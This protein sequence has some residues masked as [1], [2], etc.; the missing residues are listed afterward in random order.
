MAAPDP[1]A[2]TD[3]VVEA[4]GTV[5]VAGSSVPVHLVEV[6]GSTAV[7]YLIVTPSPGGV[8][9][10]TLGAPDDD[11]DL[12]VLVTSVTDRQ[13]DGQGARQ[14]QVLQ[15]I[16]QQAVLGGLTVEGR[17]VLRARLDI[18]GGVALDRESEPA[19]FF[20]VDRYRIATTP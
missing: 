3:A 18:P 2:V 5:T 17:T 12:V 9:D 20:A 7:P 11:G 8:L 10:G 6:P 1:G 4:L 16:T 13:A 19:R 14:C 15:R